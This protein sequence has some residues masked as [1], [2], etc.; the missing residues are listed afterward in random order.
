MTYSLCVR[1]DNI[2][3]KA[4]LC[5][6]EQMFI[7]NQCICLG[8]FSVW[9]RDGDNGPFKIKVKT[10][11]ACTC[12]RV[13]R[14]SSWNRHGSRTTSIVG[15]VCVG[16]QTRSVTNAVVKVFVRSGHKN[17][18]V[19]MTTSLMIGGSFGVMVT[20]TNTRLKSGNEMR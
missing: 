20:V 9:Q 8:L 4:G 15:K 16:E 17:L 10:H 1:L 6:S 19:K 5:S 7:G 13:G 11:V 2:G 18:C 3:R 12:P 14:C